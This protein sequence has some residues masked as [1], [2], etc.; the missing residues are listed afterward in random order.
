[1][2]IKR[3]LFILITIFSLGTVMLLLPIM[4]MKTNIREVKQMRASIDFP[5]ADWIPCRSQIHE[6][7]PRASQ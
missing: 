7:R 4:G 1:M 2:G 6:S 3:T 5:Q